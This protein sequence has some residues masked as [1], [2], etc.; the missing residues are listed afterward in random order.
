AAWW[1][2][3]AFL[4]GDPM[5]YMLGTPSWWL[6]QRPTPIPV[7]IASFFDRDQWTDWIALGLLIATVIGTRWLVQRGELRLGLYA[8]AC[9][10]SCALDT[11]TVMPRLLAIA[12]P[13]FAGFAAALPS[14]WWRA[15]ALLLSAGGQVAFGAAVTVRLIVP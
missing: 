13:A 8:L 6:N 14:R 3:I 9:I 12:F 15:G 5:G 4:T 10:A 11:Q 7:G 2:W 1:T